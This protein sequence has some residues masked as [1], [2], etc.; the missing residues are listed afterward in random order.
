MNKII[1][2]YLAVLALF[3]LSSCGTIAQVVTSKH[4]PY[5]SVREI[6]FLTPQNKNNSITIPL[7]LTESA[8]RFN[9]G[10]VIRKIETTTDDDSIYF[11]IVSCAAGGKIS[12]VEKPSILIENQAGHSK[13][14][15]YYLEPDG[16]K[17][18][19]GNVVINSGKVNNIFERGANF[20]ALHSRLS[21]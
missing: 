8:F 13:Y 6:A 4:E 1:S 21:R 10:I 3:L 18:R 9:S 19:V 12:V 14:T 11:Y 5:E 16:T 7:D 2:A 15:V 20:D 17:H